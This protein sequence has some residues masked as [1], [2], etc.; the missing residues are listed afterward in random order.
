MICLV[1]GVDQECQADSRD[2]ITC[3]HCLNK[4]DWCS[5]PFN[6]THP[7]LKTISCK[8]MCVKWV[9]EPAPGKVTYTRTCSEKLNILM[10]I[11]HVCMPCVK[12]TVEELTFS[13]CFGN[14]VILENPKIV[15]FEERNCVVDSFDVT[16]AEE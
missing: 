5:D 10:N 1:F 9:R 6:E 16:T 2:P 15:S 8:G 11:Y 3:Y 7:Q 4:D 14:S 13:N 12:F